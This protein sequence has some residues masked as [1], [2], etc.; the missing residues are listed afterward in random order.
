MKKTILK[1]ILS[2]FII[3]IC[4]SFFVS[5]ASLQDRR[6]HTN[7]KDVYEL[8]LAHASQT[9]TVTDIFAQKFAELVEEKSKGTI[10]VNIYP[11]SQ[12]GG[13]IEITEAVQRG[14]ITFVVQTTAP[15]VAFV[16][17]A[18]IFDVPMAFKNLTIARKVL[19]GKLYEKLKPYYE[20]KHIR[21]LAYAD[22]GYRVMS[23]NKKIENID[24]LKGIKIRT[25]ENANH[26][27]LWK[28]AGAN[29]TPMTWAE[30]YVGLQQGI[31]DAQENPIEVIV[32]SKVYEQQEYV[33]KTNHILHILS[34]IASPSVLDAL[35]IELQNIIQE[36][37]DEAKIYARLQT[38]E[39]SEGRIK[40]LKESNIQILEYNDKLF[41]QMQDKT[42]KVWDNIEHNIDKQ[43]LDTLRSEI[44][45][46]EREN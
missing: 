5:C 31:I 15:Q 2:I 14:N 38:D 11:N 23:S 40:I 17:E 37:A 35:P 3:I 36:S 45:L 4:V 30:V 6:K 46:A 39:R 44:Q 7:K 24:D 22:Q 1:K 42:K 12:L 16:P 34:L 28:L 19:D 21:L 26:V 33:I 41:R 13:D 32:A 10:K 29:P 8:Y 20:K 43:L 25:M 18:S 9:D 27:A